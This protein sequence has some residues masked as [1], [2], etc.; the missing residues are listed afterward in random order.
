MNSPSFRFTAG[1][2]LVVLSLCALSA[3]PAWSQ[4]EPSPPSAEQAVAAGEDVI[5]ETI[6]VA[7]QRPGPGLWKV[8]KGD[9]VLWVFGTYS[10]LPKKM[11]W[12][13]KE[14][15]A[16]LAQ[17]QEYLQPPG[18]TSNVGFFR[19]MTLLPFAIG[20]KKNPDGAELKDLLPEPVYARWLVLKKK[21][22]GDDDGIERERP[23][24]AADTLF[25][26]GL[27]QAGLGSGGREVRET[28]EKLVKQSKIKMTSTV[29]KLEI[30]DPVKMLREFKKSSLDD[31]ACFS[32]TMARL[33][34]DID[35]M[36]VRANAWAKGDLEAIQKI[37]YA[38]RDGACDSAVLNSA[39]LQ[40]RPGLNSVQQKIQDSWVAAAEKSLAANVSTFATLPVKDLLDP[41][42]FVAALE[43]KGYVV[44]KPE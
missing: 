7:G 24:F 10:P 3:A 22:I 31:V 4:T 38:D 17:S 39:L 29:A 19:Q 23:I 13:S 32:N 20:F 1:R 30:D 33:E 35:A 18:A 2:S 15:E 11:E 28:I 27:E 36:R 12:R 41:K 43:A 21:Y 42:G 6:L 25:R 8:S 40:S 9:H 16:I 5:A 34:D 44:Q 37:S 14:V 26:K